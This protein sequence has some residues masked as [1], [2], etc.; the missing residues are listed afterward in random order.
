MLMVFGK[1]CGM[2]TLMVGLKVIFF[3]S[4]GDFYFL[5]Y[6]YCA[7]LKMFYNEFI[8]CKGYFLKSIISS[9]IRAC[10]KS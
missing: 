3:F 8:T 5:L 7:F 4:E 10:I 9:A 2:L 6:V 1:K